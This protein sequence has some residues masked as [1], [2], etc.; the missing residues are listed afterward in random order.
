MEGE[1][2]KKIFFDPKTLMS[3]FMAGSG[4]ILWVV[5]FVFNPIN[6]VKTD[7]ALIQKDIQII[8]TNHLSHIQDIVA[9]LEKIKE[10]EVKI[11]KDLAITNTVLMNHLNLSK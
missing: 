11:E 6:T 2:K 9:R 3:A 4:V 8:N 7:I 5:S 10:D 1:N